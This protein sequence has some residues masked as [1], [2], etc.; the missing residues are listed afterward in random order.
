[1]I[2]SFAWTTGAL[3]D[4]LKTVT[5]RLWKDSHAEKFKAGQIV[6]AYDRLPRSGG[7]KVATIRLTCDPYKE[8]LADM[9]D[10]DLILE[11]GLWEDKTDFIDGFGGDPE[12]KVW[13]V[14]FELVKGTGQ[15]K[16][17]FAETD[18]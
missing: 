16:L 11:G 4:G 9:P 1:L 15:M 2:I 6:D 17:S 8:R 14:R 7:H 3:L 10:G 12:L 18:E 13:V 5:R